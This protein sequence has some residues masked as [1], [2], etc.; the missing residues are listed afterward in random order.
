MPEY[1]Q[2]GQ[3]KANELDAEAEQHF[4]EGE[5]AGTRADD[6]VRVTV[7]LASVLFLI[8]ISTQFR[9]RGARL[10]LVAVGGGMLLLSIIQLAN[11]PAP[12]G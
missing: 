7:Y 9:L 8:G 10:G 11:L 4:K 1:E 12:P 6:F 2:P 3:D 5:E